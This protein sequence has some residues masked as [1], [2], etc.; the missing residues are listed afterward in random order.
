MEKVLTILAIIAFAAFIIYK[1]CEIVVANR[2]YKRIEQ[3]YDDFI[4]D[5]IKK[6]MDKDE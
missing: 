4:F 5:L 3:D 6:F 2:F 1:V